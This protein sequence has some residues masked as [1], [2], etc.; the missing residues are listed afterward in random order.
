MNK[1]SIIIA[2]PSRKYISVATNIIAC[3]Y[4]N[5]AIKQKRFI[6]HK[7]NRSNLI[8]DLLNNSTLHSIEFPNEF[9]KHIF[10]TYG[11]KT[12]SFNDPVY[13]LC[14]TFFGL[15]EIQCY[16]G[17]KDRGSDTHLYWEDIPMPL[18]K[19]CKFKHLNSK[20]KT[21]KI[22]CN[23]IFDIVQNVIISKIDRNALA[24]ALHYEVQHSNVKLAIIQNPLLQNDIT[25]GTASL[26]K[27]IR[28]ID[29]DKNEKNYCLKDMP[30]GEFDLVLQE[31]NFKNLTATVNNWFRDYKLYE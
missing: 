5:S 31:N 1:L 22:S 26:A 8:C 21:G 18:R 29:S 6:P 15:D 16:G 25:M 20:D 30:L 9:Q 27:A 13:K 28:I 17:D 12:Y 14:M 11:I 2:S 3:E 23:E 4:L 19:L 24:R 7:E 10:E